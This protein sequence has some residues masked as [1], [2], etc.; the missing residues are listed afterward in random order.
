[1]CSRSG[2]D[3]PEKPEESFV[4]QDISK[5]R[6]PVQQACNTRN[7]RRPS[8]AT[9][10]GGPEK[11]EKPLAEQETATDQWSVPQQAGNARNEGRLPMPTSWGA[12]EKPEKPLAGEETV[13]GQW[14]VPQDRNKR[15][16]FA[17]SRP[18]VGAASRGGTRSQ[19]HGGHES[20][21]R[22]NTSGTSQPCSYK[23]RFVVKKHKP[24]G[25]GSRSQFLEQGQ[26]SH[27]YSCELLT[28]GARS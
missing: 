17:H 12:P 4:G 26:L 13:T 6:C 28:R 21:T 19:Q 15:H 1:M 23:D 2:W 22:S 16:D 10:W 27:Y 3:A 25:M 5:G 7:V 11:L 8:M 14:S 9:R 20:S 18:E 24:E